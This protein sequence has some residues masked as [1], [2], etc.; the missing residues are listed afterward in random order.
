MSSNLA[1]PPP[2]Q[3]LSLGNTILHYTS[4]GFHS[5][6]T[7]VCVCVCPST[8]PDASIHDG[9]LQ[10]SLCLGEM[11]ALPCLCVCLCE[12]MWGLQSSRLSLNHRGAR[13]AE[14]R[15]EE[16]GEGSEGS[17]GLEFQ[18]LH[19]VAHLEVSNQQ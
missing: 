10:L 6:P 14:E 17:E 12:V 18:Q 9:V 8:S 19:T 5:I 3:P 2:L 1:F 7:C 11:T 15:A 16:R 4:A 13:R